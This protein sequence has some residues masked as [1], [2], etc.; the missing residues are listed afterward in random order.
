MAESSHQPPP[1]EIVVD[2]SK[3]EEPKQAAA[4]PTLRAEL[5]SKGEATGST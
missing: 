5:S 3:L 1:V 2:I 4:R